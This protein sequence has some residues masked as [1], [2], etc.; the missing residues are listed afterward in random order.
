MTLP[1]KL[2]AL[3]L[4]LAPVI[5]AL[6]Q[7]VATSASWL[8]FALLFVAFVVGE[9]TDFLDGKIARAQ[10]LVTNLGKVLDPFSDLVLH[11]T[12]F[13]VFS[14]Y[15]LMPGI[16]FIIILYREVGMTFGRLAMARTGV[17]LA[18]SWW[19]KAKTVCYAAGSAVGFIAFAATY[20]SANPASGFADA[21]RIIALV[22][23]ALSALSSAVSFCLYLPTIAGALTED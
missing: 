18:A 4:C 11:L 21:V 19:G 5:F 8:L 22:L 3:R 17:A 20:V 15:G 13:Y 9:L 14:L 7:L 6:S 1:N 12:M 2:S 23:F 10:G 16:F